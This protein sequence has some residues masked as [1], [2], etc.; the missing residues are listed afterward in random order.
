VIAI[1]DD[2][3]HNKS[4]K[5]TGDVHLPSGAG[6]TPRFPAFRSGSLTVNWYSSLTKSASLAQSQTARR[7]AAGAPGGTAPLGIQRLWRGSYA[8]DNP[9]HA[10]FASRRLKKP[11][12]S[13][14]GRSSESITIFMLATTKRWAGG[15]LQCRNHSRLAFWRVL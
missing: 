15:G 5:L 10:Y 13:L 2:I 6:K 3:I 11:V 9:I 8:A 14:R 1:L 12:E 7:R 4:V